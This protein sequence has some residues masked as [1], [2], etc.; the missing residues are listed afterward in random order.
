M[1]IAGFVYSLYYR[2]LGRKNTNSKKITLKKKIHQR[3]ISIFKGTEKIFYFELNFN[4]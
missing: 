3:M 4:N 2:T 1:Y